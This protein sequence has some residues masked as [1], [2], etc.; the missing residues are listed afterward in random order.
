[1]SLHA[2]VYSKAALLLF[3]S[4]ALFAIPSSSSFESCA[5][6]VEDSLPPDAFYEEL[7]VIPMEDGSV[8]THL[9]FE[10]RVILVLFNQAMEHISRIA[11]IV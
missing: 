9:Q 1:M 7:L 2:S 6:V 11:R 5:S 4:S 10:V 3:A 8:M